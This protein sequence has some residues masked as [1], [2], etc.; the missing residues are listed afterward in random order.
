MMLEYQF[1]A[2]NYS[3]HNLDNL[4]RFAGSDVVLDHPVERSKY[5]RMQM[6]FPAALLE[7]NKISPSSKAML[8]IPN[9]LSKSLLGW[10]RPLCSISLS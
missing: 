2:F 7:G 6:V 9:T 1:V 4:T 10:E 8:R 5:H 3:G